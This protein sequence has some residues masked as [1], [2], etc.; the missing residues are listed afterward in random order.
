MVKMSPKKIKTP[1]KDVVIHNNEKK[2]A[3]FAKLD[4][5]SLNKSIVAG[6]DKI[7]PKDETNIPDIA[8]T[9]IKVEPN[10]SQ[11]KM[12]IK[13]PH[14]NAS[15]EKTS[16]ELFNNDQSSQ[17]INEHP[18]DDET[19]A[20]EEN[21]DSSVGDEGQSDE[22]E[23]SPD[24]VSSIG[25]LSVDED[26]NAVNR[27]APAGPGNGMDTQGADEEQEVQADD[28]SMTLSED[29]VQGMSSQMEDVHCQSNEHGE[30]HEYIVGSFSGIPTDHIN[31][32]TK[33]VNDAISEVTRVFHLME[34]YVYHTSENDLLISISKNDIH[35]VNAAIDSQMDIDSG[36]FPSSMCKGCKL[37][38]SAGELFDKKPAVANAVLGELARTPSGLVKGTKSDTLIMDPM[39]LAKSQIETEVPKQTPKKSGNRRKNKPSSK[40]G[41]SQTVNNPVVKQT[42]LL[43]PKQHI[44]LKERLMVINH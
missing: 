15:L 33:F 23:T 39:S 19:P 32:V 6:Q 17:S 9:T 3:D 40:A 1:K 22:E 43:L 44:F 20:D 42:T 13:H 26:G 14:L 7:S 30:D 34:I 31:Q 35:F 24:N 4:V 21:N 2:L 29:F 28:V 11:R 18:V 25:S 10:D 37:K 5:E 12:R 36:R 16:E 38:L 8:T 41:V 27:G